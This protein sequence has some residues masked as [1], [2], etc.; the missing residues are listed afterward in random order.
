M[1]KEDI[2]EFNGS[3]AILSHDALQQNKFGVIVFEGEIICLN[4]YK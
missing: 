4:M 3:W 1:P 2:V